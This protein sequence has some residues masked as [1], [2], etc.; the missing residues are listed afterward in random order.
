MTSASLW[1]APVQLA[2]VHRIWTTGLIIDSS[3]AISSGCSPQRLSFSRGRIIRYGRPVPSKLP[4]F[5]PLDRK[6]WL[7]LKWNIKRHWFQLLQTE[8]GVGGRKDGLLPLNRCL[9]TEKPLP[10][11]PGGG[12]GLPLT[13]QLKAHTI[14]LFLIP[15]PHQPLW[16][17]WHY[18]RPW[19]AL[20]SHSCSPIVRTTLPSSAEQ[21]TNHI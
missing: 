16:M 19:Q 13:V 12:L 11:H 10:E 17:T 6:S 2:E 3:K 14:G 1:T 5:L 20:R 7:D 8:T 18:L 9:W 4:I 15:I 21:T